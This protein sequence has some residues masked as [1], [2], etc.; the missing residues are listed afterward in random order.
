ME[1]LAFGFS[2]E[3]AR[4]VVARLL[5][6]CRELLEA[7]LTLQMVGH[8]RCLVSQACEVRQL[9]SRSRTLLMAEA[10][11][12]VRS[13]WGN[14]HSVYTH[15]HDSIVLV[16]PALSGLLGVSSECLISV[17]RTT[18]CHDSMASCCLAW[19]LLIPE[20]R[21]RLLDPT[22]S[23]GSQNVHSVR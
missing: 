1:G 3:R 19:M 16:L 2:R 5:I 11:M 15:S 9:C 10:Q 23:S 7:T 17:R 21:C 6:V 14:A 12:I 13:A 20:I 22:E 18:V 8:A 4:V